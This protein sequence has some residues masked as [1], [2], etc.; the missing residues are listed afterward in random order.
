MHMSDFFLLSI[1]LSDPQQH[2]LD[3]GGDG[4]HLTVKSCIS[5]RV[6]DRLADQLRLMSTVWEGA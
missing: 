3:C 6:R 1:K 4:Q 5:C 2:T